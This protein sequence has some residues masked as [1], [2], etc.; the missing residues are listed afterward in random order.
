MA[1]FLNPSVT[2]FY[3][4]CYDCWFIVGA[5]MLSNQLFKVCQAIFTSSVQYTKRLNLYFIWETFLVLRESTYTTLWMIW[6][7]LYKPLGF[8]HAR[9]PFNVDFSIYSYRLSTTSYR[10]IFFAL[11]S[12]FFSR[13]H[14]QSVLSAGFGGNQ[15]LPMICYCFTRCYILLTMLLFAPW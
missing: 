9:L 10:W 8:I 13:L 3:E 14:F 6:N 2:S 7:N 12:V 1:R 4:S 15:R 5:V 11:F